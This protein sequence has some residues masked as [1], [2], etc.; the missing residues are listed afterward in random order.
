MLSN[1]SGETTS[2]TPA[3]H[4]G[5]AQGAHVVAG[6]EHLADRLADFLARVTPEGKIRFV[7]LP[8]LEWL[9]YGDKG[10]AKAGNL[11][12][13]VAEGDRGALRGA[14]SAGCGVDRQSL[15]LD[16]LRADAIPIR[17]T[18]RILPLI[19]AGPAP[20][21]CSRPGRW[22]RLPL[23]AWITTP[24]SMMSS[25]ACRPVPIYCAAWAS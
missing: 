23:P 24:A 11:A 4:S 25:P 19:M 7:S 21:C 15:N 5:P 20:S 1:N 18:C 6:A 3:S 9:G 14:L 12:D 10:A 8:G 16:L 13:L 2:K 22:A 17:V